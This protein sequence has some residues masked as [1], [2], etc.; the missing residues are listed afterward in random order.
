MLRLF[1]AWAATTRNND[2]VRMEGLKRLVSS[3][4]HRKEL[5]AGGLS[6][7]LTAGASSPLLKDKVN[8]DRFVEYRNLVDRLGNHASD[9]WSAYE[10]AYADSVVRLVSLLTLPL[11]ELP[12]VRPQQ[13]IFSHVQISNC[14]RSSLPFE[15]YNSHR[16]YRSPWPLSFLCN[17]HQACLRRTSECSF[18]KQ[19]KEP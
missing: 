3:S 6:A 17:K 9:F 1:L 14:F 4:K 2:Y 7:Y 11:S 16:R 19:G 5:V 8:T 12:Q 13:S 18:I 10:N 15:Q